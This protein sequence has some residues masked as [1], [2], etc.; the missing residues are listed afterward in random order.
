MKINGVRR[1][2]KVLKSGDRIS[3]GLLDLL[4][5]PL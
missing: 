2:K 4:F 5:R 3:L 1:K